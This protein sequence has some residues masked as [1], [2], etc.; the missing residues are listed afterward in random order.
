MSPMAYEARMKFDQQRSGV[1]PYGSEPLNLPAP[2]A[3]G[4]GP[5]DPSGAAPSVSGIA[6]SGPRWP[7]GKSFAFTIV[8]DT[9]SA[10][11]PRVRPVYDFLRENG[12]LTTKTVWPLKPV[13]PPTLGGG[14]LQDPEYCQWILELQQAGFEIAFHGASAETSLRARTLEGLEY[15]RTVLG[16]YPRLHAN[17]VGQREAIY[18]GEAR[19][20]GLAATV[21]RLAHRLRGKVRRFY[22]HDETTD[23]FWGDFCRDR[24]TYVRNFT[25]HDI[26]TT[27]Q[28]G[29]MPYRDPRRP[30]VAY[31]FSS[32]FGPV[33]EEFCKTI[34][35]ANQDRLVEEGG[36][37][38][39]YAHLAYGF[40]DD[41]RVAPTFARL[42]KRLAG[43]KGWFVPAS[44]ML[45]HLR[46]LPGWRREP[47]P[48][49]LRRLQ[50]RW[51]LSQMRHGTG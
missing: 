17:H 42:M 40:S 29:L 15:F 12:F 13:G 21:Y 25:F 41:G 2:G 35:E 50:W 47:D 36:G 39:M 3:V 18:W 28:D 22:G 7:E 38:I 10:T 31:W 51:L 49:Q 16:Q 30:Y 9:D 20:D 4:R 32:T 37:C 43:L 1:Q 5:A 26:N 14:T 34:S 8:D 46:R 33:G 44:I 19:L 27:K 6:G 23:Y 45:D 11:L 24:V 48:G